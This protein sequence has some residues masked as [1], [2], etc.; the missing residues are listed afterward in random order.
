ML[1]AFR[2]PHLLILDEPTNHLDVDSREALIHALNDFEGAV[3]LISHDRHL[4]EASAERLWIVNN[5]TVESYDGD[6][7]SYRELLLADR[8]ARTKGRANGA[9]AKTDKAEARRAAADRRSELAP[10]RKA[11]QAAEK[12]VAQYTR[13]LAAIDGALADPQLYQRDPT[14]AQ[15]LSIERGML[16]KLLAGAED[17]WLQATDAFEQAAADR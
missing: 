5:G 12:Q 16:A 4:V 3:I 7:D 17:D 2:G 6:M 15:K 14:R 9:E 1:T 13:D 8:G 10:L 11:L